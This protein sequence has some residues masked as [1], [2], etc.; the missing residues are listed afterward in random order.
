MNPPDITNAL[1]NCRSKKKGLNQAGSHYL[2]CKFQALINKLS[3]SVFH[4]INTANVKEDIYQSGN[5]GIMTAISSYKDGNN[6]SFN[7]WAY[8]QIRN[9]L[10]KLRESMFPVKVSRYLLKKGHKAEFSTINDEYDKEIDDEPDAQ[11]RLIEQED[12]EL[13]TKALRHINNMFSNKDCHIFRS[14]YFMN[15]PLNKLSKK[16]KVNANAIVRKMILAIRDLNH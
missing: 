2:I 15:I 13:I 8:I 1:K 3:Q 12:A 9:E 10:Q 11:E 4:N 16:H 7:S 5:L 6:T 14:Y